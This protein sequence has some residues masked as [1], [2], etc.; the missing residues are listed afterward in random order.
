MKSLLN[1]SNSFEWRDVLSPLKTIKK[2]Y[3][4]APGYYSIVNLPQTSKL[5]CLQGLLRRI[6][7]MSECYLYPVGQSV[8]DRLFGTGVVH[9][10]GAYENNGMLAIV[11]NDGS[12][13]TDGNLC[14][15]NE[16]MER[17][18]CLYSQWIQKQ[19]LEVKDFITCDIE[20]DVTLNII[21]LHS[22]INIANSARGLFKLISNAYPN[23]CTCTILERYRQQFFSKTLNSSPE[24]PRIPQNATHADILE[25]LVYA[26]RRVD[27]DCKLDLR[28]EPDHHYNQG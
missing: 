3:L 9:Y 7:I 14:T 21:N 8:I 19:P 1:F 2:L 11:G 28:V 18:I 13:S 22:F 15:R 4:S 24:V 17:A 20:C 25:I 12:F 27:P 23:V 16:F 5:L 6:G 26:L 10:E